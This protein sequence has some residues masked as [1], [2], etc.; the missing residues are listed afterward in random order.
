VGV[1]TGGYYAPGGGGTQLCFGAVRGGVRLRACERAA[2]AHRPG[3]V[4]V[5]V[6]VVIV[7][8]II[9]NVHVRPVAGA[10]E[11]PRDLVLV[12]V[13][14]VLRRRQVERVREDAARDVAREEDA[15]LVGH[16]E[17]LRVVREA[18]PVGGPRGERARDGVRGAK[19]HPRDDEV[20]RA[21]VGE[22]EPDDGRGARGGQQAREVRCGEEGGIGVRVGEEGRAGE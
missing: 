15:E 4:I 18:A 2:A 5:V 7:V 3:V 19:V 12:R 11:Q 9:I 13:A 14:A 22:R 1:T 16:A 20:Q 17:V 6:I 8:V 21:R 10:H